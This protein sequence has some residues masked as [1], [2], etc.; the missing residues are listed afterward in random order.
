MPPEEI[1]RCF[2]KES[3]LLGL[4]GVSNDL[5][6]IIEAA[7][8]GNERAGLAIDV[9]C[10][11]ILKYVGAYYA[12][13]GGLDYIAFTGGIG[14]HSPLIRQKVLERVAHLGVELDH[15]RNAVDASVISGVGSP[16]KVL[17]IPANE[18]LVVARKSY[19]HMT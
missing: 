16:V 10:Y 6:D 14:E 11:A 2:S 9:Y 19:E 4:S 13:L 7:S 1:F 18:E 15:E 17:V 3:G 8:A 5:R 12:V